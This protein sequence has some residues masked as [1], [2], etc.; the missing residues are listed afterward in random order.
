MDYL[1]VIISENITQLRKEHGLTQADLAEKLNYSDK[2]VSKWERAESLPDITVLKAMADLFNVKVD[3]L[4]TAEHEQERQRETIIGKRRFRRR[5]IITGMSIM[6]VWLIATVVFFILDTVT[7]IDKH[8][9]CFV[10]AVPVSFAVWLIFN[11]I[12][13]NRYRNFLIISL[14]MWTTLGTVFIFLIG[15]R[16]WLLFLIGIPAQVIIFLWSGMYEK[17]EKS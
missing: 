17:K 7:S 10:C 2:A 13:F 4:L 1:K 5:S 3:Y 8:W 16:M 15:L 14:L 6:L 11:S 9:L 12:W